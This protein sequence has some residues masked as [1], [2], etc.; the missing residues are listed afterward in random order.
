VLAVAAG[1]LTVLGSALTC[2]A[3]VNASVAEAA[4]LGV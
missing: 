3:D 4:T 1:V 2:P